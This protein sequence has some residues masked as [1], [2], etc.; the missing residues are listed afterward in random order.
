[1]LD[2]RL[3]TPI[4]QQ[5][6]PKL[7]EF[8]Y[9]IQY[10]KGKVNVVAYALSRVEGSEVLNM[11]MTVPPLLSFTGQMERSEAS[12]SAISVVECEFLKEIQ[13]AYENDIVLKGVI[14]ELT[15][16]A[17]AKKHYSWMQ[18]ILRRKSKIVV[19]NDV[20][21]KNP[22]LQWLH[23][24]GAGGHSGKEVTH[25]RVKSIFY[26]KG[27]VKDIQAFIR[28]CSV[29]QQCKSDTAAPPGLLQPLPIPNAI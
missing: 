18:N 16:K 24:S 26:W 11:A 6:L 19:P 29:C 14:E 1:M 5:W 21:I 7:L 22:I 12:M 27:M 17:D 23:S 3:N 2:Q 10:R 13:A 4:Q 25:K 20:Q 28:S 9:V 8:D 15:R